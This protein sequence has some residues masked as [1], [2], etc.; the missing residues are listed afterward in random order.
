MAFL[1]KKTRKAIRK[2]VTKAIN[3]HGPDVAAHLAT[4]FTA[5]VAT[6]MGAEGDKVPRKM[7]K[8]MK[9]IAGSKV[10]KAVA[11]AIPALSGNGHEHKNHHRH[12]AEDDEEDSG[13]KSQAA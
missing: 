13:K 6:Y 11:A 1:K 10:G 2:I 8:V 4:A 12:H 9:D 7:K 3:K 5:A